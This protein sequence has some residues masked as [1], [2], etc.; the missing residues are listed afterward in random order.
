VADARFAK[1]LDQ[2]LVRRLA[3]EHEV[4]VTVEEGAIGGFATQ[5]MQFMAQEGLLDN[6]L[7]FRPLTLP[8]IFIDHDKPAVQIEMAGLDAPHI[9]ASVLEALGRGGEALEAPARA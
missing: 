5:V 2:D 1:P 9:V 6:G 8:D 3:R 4:L 7:R